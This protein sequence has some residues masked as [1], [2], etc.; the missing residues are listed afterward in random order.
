M[1]RGRILHAGLS[2]VQALRLAVS[3]MAALLSTLVKTFHVARMRTLAACQWP[4]V[5]PF[6]GIDWSLTLARRN[7]ELGEMRLEGST[8]AEEARVVQLIV[9]HLIAKENVLVVVEQPEQEGDEADEAYRARRLRERVLA[10][11]PNY[12]EA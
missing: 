1:S 6:K 3:M 11:S 12:T 4:A 5:S 10:I 2:T 7:E 9:A 8:M